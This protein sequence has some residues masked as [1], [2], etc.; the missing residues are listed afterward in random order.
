MFSKGSGY[1]DMPVTVPCGRCAGCRLEYSRQWAVRCIHEA[2]M[3]EENSF[4]TLTYD[5]KHLPEDR[6]VRKEEIQKFMKRLRKEVR[7]P[8]RYFACGEY[9]EGNNRPHYHALIFGYGFPDKTLW[10]KKN[11]NL[12]FRSK[13]LEKAWTKGFASIGEVTFQSAAYVAR[14]VMKKRTGDEAEKH[15]QIL[16]KESGEIFQQEPEFC[17]MSRRPGIGK[18][19][20]EKF[21]GDTNKDFITVNGKKMSLP[22][23][24]DSILEKDNELAM[25][26]RKARRKNKVNKEDNTLERLRVK[27]KVKTAQ[28][29]MLV[30]N[31]EE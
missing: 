11:G 16:D 19:W 2:Q 22:K 10:S 12:L 31:L 7:K 24:Y 23:Y 13:T 20:I 29:N 4:I 14:Y 21:K 26:K 9:G 17:L 25:M 6:S 30:R 8:I 28:I 3:H 27:E 1:T 5:P 18:E 15:Y